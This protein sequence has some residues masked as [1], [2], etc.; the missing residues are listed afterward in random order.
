MAE[1]IKVLLV[2]DI[3]S[4]LENLQKLLSFEDD[5]KVIGTATNGLEA[6][7][8]T[9]KLNPDITLMDVNMPKM[10]GIKATEILA[11]EAPNSPVI[12][13]SVQGER[14]Y[15]RR[16]M[17]AG[18]REFL[19]KPFS[20]EEL[21]SSI[22]RVHQLE[23]RK[24]I[25]SNQPKDESD[26]PTV[27]ALEEKDINENLEAT[28]ANVE[29]TSINSPEAAVIVKEAKESVTEL[30]VPIDDA[31]S[32]EAEGS[33][34]GEIIV[35][36]G[37]K[38]GIGTSVITTNLACSIANETNAKVAIVD[39]DLQFGDQ[40]IL[41]G[42]SQAQSITDLIENLGSLDKEYIH[43]IMPLGPGGVRLLPTPA[44][45][46]L[47]DLVTPEHVVRILSE[48]QAIFDFIVVDTSAH[49]GDITLT[50][51]DLAHSLVLITST[52]IPSVKNSKLTLKLFDTLNL[53]P[54]KITMV[55]NR[56]ESHVEFQKENIEGHLKFPFKVQLPYD[57]RT[58]VNSINRAAPF[59]LSN[60]ESEISQKIRELVACVVPEQL[61]TQLRVHKSSKTK[62]FGRR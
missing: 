13:M 31:N 6:I 46:E 9:K 30:A 24:E 19:I 27:P 1:V 35:L 60:P 11:K 40:G 56:P 28:M 49:L 54:S 12:I 44:S 36:Y 14:D 2:D 51:M 59:I 48:L 7:E 57:S 26:D 16:A 25:Y 38:G 4:T 55:L 47:A 29:S 52:T 10:D 3:S 21:T 32:D 18:S 43:E 62:L 5:I 61:A 58:V 33:T 20:H 34:Y 39:L 53:D 23:R 45:P 37:G 15:L 8:A 22:R 17:Q 41:L 50:A 42:I